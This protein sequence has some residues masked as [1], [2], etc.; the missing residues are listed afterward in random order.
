MGGSSG[1]SAFG[2]TTAT[3]SRSR[4]QRSQTSTKAPPDKHRR[5]HDRK[6]DGQQ[7]EARERIIAF[8]DAPLP[9]PVHQRLARQLLIV[10]QGV[11]FR[12]FVFFSHLTS[13]GHSAQRVTARK[14]NTTSTHIA[15]STAHSDRR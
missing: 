13:A 9:A 8:P 6:E 10:A 4:V 12:R 2:R 11:N 14:L 7:L 15:T 1:V 5:R 3:I